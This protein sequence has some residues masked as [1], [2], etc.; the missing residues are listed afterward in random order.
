MIWKNRALYPQNPCLAGFRPA[1]KP[2]QVLKNV[3]GFAGF[4]VRQAMLE[5]LNKNISQAHKNI[6]LL[7]WIT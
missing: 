2:L 7:L 4:L 6:Q 1:D 5:N 3:A